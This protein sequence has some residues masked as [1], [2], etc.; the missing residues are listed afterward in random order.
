M[1]QRR[2]RGSSSAEDI[3]AHLDE[4]NNTEGFIIPASTSDEIM[5]LAEKFNPPA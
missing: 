1:A 2:I 5:A 3:Q 4:I